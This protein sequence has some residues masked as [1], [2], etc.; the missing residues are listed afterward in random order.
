MLNWSCK[1]RAKQIQTKKHK[2]KFLFLVWCWSYFQYITDQPAVPYFKTCTANMKV[3]TF[4]C[5]GL[6]V[7]ENVFIEK[8]LYQN[9]IFE[10]YAYEYGVCFRLSMYSPWQILLQEKHFFNLMS[11]CFLKHAVKEGRI[12]IIVRNQLPKMNQNIR[13]KLSSE[14]LFVREVVPT[15]LCFWIF[16]WYVLFTWEGECS[17]KVH[18]VFRKKGM[19][20]L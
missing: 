20:Y 15:R 17:F 3:F 8:N 19:L 10:W 16:N 4:T 14:Q 5:F 1:I 13:C 12:C 11:N 2:C 7:N 9:K 18:Y 6:I